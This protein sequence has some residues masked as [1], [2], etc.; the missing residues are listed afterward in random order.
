MD[1]RKEFLIRELW[2]SAW[3]ASVQH[4]SLY[5]DGARKIRRDEINEFRSKLINYI[6]REIIPIYKNFVSEDEHIRN[7][8]KIIDFANKADTGI[9]GRDLYK[10]GVAQKLLNLALKY[11]WCLAEVVEPPHCPVDRI[12]IDKT[13]YKGKINWTQIMFCFKRKWKTGRPMIV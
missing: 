5:I 13:I 1:K 7:I 10:F 9:L 11:Y 4:A 12:I 2:I 8:L 6:K 3:S